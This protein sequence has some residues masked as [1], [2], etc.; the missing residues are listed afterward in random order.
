MSGTLDDLPGKL[1]ASA[2][3]RP[4]EKAAIAVLT[5]HGRWLRHPGFL[6]LCIRSFRDQTWIH[7]PIVRRF[8]ASTPCPALDE[9]VLFLASELALWESGRRLRESTVLGTMNDT[10]YQQPLRRRRPGAAD[11]SAPAVAAIGDG[12]MSMDCG[13]PCCAI[14]TQRL[15]RPP[16]AAGLCRR[17]ASAAIAAGEP[18]ESVILGRMVASVITHV[19][20]QI[21][22]LPEGQELAELVAS[23]ALQIYA[24]GLVDPARAS[25]RRAGTAQRARCPGRPGSRLPRLPLTP[26][27]LSAPCARPSPRAGRRARTRG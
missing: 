20:P 13:H 3:D 5:R 6:L 26:T 23:K 14:A 18:V 11:Q 21:P 16:G 17:C 2:T 9:E 8:L 10:E 12:V 22:G 15:P 27:L 4:G 19:A 25:P 7:W 1:S 24:D